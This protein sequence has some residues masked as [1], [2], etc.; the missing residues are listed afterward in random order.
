[1]RRAFIRQYLYNAAPKPRSRNRDTI[2]E[3]QTMR[4][5]ALFLPVFLLLTGSGWAADAIN[6]SS[7]AFVGTGQQKLNTSVVIVGGGNKDFLFRANGPS[8]SG[9]VSGALQDPY[10]KVVDLDQKGDFIGKDALLKERDAGQRFHIMG[11]TVDQEYGLE[12][13]VE[14]HALVEGVAKKVGTCPSM[15]WS[16]GLSCW[17]GLASVQTEFVKRDLV[18]YVQAGEREIECRK[19]KL[20]FVNLD[21]YR[22]VPAPL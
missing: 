15:A 11:F 12:E 2:C 22:A 3:T 7:R 16:Y 21:R 14:L 17:L 1:M 10:L 9:Q 20:P 18:Y 19:S 4:L 6:L 5:F 13:E 8:M